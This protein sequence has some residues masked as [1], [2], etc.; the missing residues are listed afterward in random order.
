MKLFVAIYDDTV[1]LDQFLRHYE[2]RGV[3]EFFVAIPEGE[4]EDL[5]AVAGHDVT[6]VEGLDVKNSVYGTSAVTAMRERFQHADEWAVVVDLDEFVEC[7]SLPEVAASA[8]RAGANLVRGIMHDRFSVDGRPRD[9]APDADL[10]DVYPIKARFVREV[11]QGCDHKGVLVKGQLRPAPGK[12][13]HVFAGELGYADVLEISHY[14]WTAAGLERVEVKRQIAR[15]A[16]MPWDDAYQ[17]ALDHYARHGR[18][19]WETFGGKPSHEFVPEPPPAH[20]DVCGAAMSEAE[21]A[22]SSERFGRPLCRTHQAAQ[23]LPTSA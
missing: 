15:D 23:R 16:G 18:F 22:Y 7:P 21:L 6:L 19:A 2:T 11:M 13:H 12:Q 10:Q 1:L 3:R 5:E 9:F 14:R 20:C 4:R 8:E 17:R